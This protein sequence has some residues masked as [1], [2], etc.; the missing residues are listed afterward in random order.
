MT[1]GAQGHDTLPLG[2]AAGEGLLVRFGLECLR[3]M[4][5]SGSLVF[6]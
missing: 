3:P 4:K 5:N 1:N 2:C 6:Q